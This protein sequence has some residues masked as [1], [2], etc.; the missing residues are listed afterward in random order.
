MGSYRECA[1]DPEGVAGIDY[2]VAAAVEAG[3]EEGGG[4]D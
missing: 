3:P 2:F 1:A 4:R